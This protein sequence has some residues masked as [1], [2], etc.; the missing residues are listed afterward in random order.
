MCSFG[1]KRVILYADEPAYQALEGNYPAELLQPATLESYGTEF[2]DYK[3][4]IKTVNDVVEA[5]THIYTYGSGHS[6]CIVT[7]DKEAAAFFTRAVDAACVYVN[8]PTS[9]TDG[10]QFW[11]GSR[12]WYQYPETA[13]S[14]SDGIKGDDY[15]QVDCGR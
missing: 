8:A 12:N 10:A 7:E 5:V 14:W 9:F 6:E 3:M 1:G 13:C 15:L 11:F 2:L 4:A